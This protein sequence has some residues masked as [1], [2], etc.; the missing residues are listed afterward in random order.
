MSEQRKVKTE[1]RVQINRCYE[2]KRVSKIKWADLKHARKDEKKNRKKKHC[3]TA[4]P[5]LASGGRHAGMHKAANRG[6]EIWTVVNEG[7]VASS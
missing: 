1:S 2:R 3:T 5:E 6:F 4:T 7:S